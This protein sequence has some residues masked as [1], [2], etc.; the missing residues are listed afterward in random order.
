MITINLNEEYT[1]EYIV[2]EVEKIEK[3]SLVITFPNSVVYRFVASVDIPNSKVIVHLPAL[4]KM[5]RREIDATEYLEVGNTDRY[6]K[7]NVEGLSFKYVVEEEP[8][9]VIDIPDSG[10][11]I[12]VNYIN[13]NIITLP[14]ETVVLKKRKIQ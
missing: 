14:P 6:Y 8:D 4:E 1:L 10:V 12:E 11:P 9:I 2:N 13:E 5:I 3:V 7:V